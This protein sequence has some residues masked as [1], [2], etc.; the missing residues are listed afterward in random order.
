MFYKKPEEEEIKGLKGKI[1]LETTE[2]RH[3]K[4]QIAP[5]I[6]SRGGDKLA[7]SIIIRIKN[8]FKIIELICLE[9]SDRL[10][11][12]LK[13]DYY[14]CKRIPVNLP[15]IDNDVPGTAEFLPELHWY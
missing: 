5:D 4:I 8:Y 13:E 6:K 2:I 10:W 11:K 12:Q 15:R 14:L 3:L 9:L 1:N 7:L